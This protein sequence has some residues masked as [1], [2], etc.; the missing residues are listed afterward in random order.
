[1]WIIAVD[2]ESEFERSALVHAYPTT[3]KCLT[4][5]SQLSER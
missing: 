3:A 2:G 5:V 4:C 1:M